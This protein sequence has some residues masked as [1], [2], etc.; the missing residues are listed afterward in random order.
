MKNI[1]ENT[2]R[3]WQMRIEAK[4]RCGWEASRGFRR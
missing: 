2:F 4:L 3:V 1:I